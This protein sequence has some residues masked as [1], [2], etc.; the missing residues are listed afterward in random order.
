MPAAATRFVTEK[1][2]CP[3]RSLRV[4]TI[5][6]NPGIRDEI[7]RTLTA[8][9][10]AAAAAENGAEA[11]GWSSASASPIDVLITDLF[12]PDVNGLEVASCLRRQWPA[13][14]VV[15]LTEVHDAL[16]DIPPSLPLLSKPFTAHALDQAIRRAIAPNRAG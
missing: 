8:Q 3:A 7:V 4:L 16:E 10:H 1:P 14:G 12:L 13:I 2:D 11:I 15:F 9:G 5:S 6:Q